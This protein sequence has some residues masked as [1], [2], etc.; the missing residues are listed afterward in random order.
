M[1]SAELSIGI[2]CASIS[3]YKP[4]FTR[5]F[6]STTVSDS[7]SENLT[8]LTPQQSEKF[9]GARGRYVTPH[10]GGNTDIDEHNWDLK[11]S[12]FVSSCSSPTSE[13]KFD[14]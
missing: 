4:L 6:Q 10:S 8:S 7:E 9:Q 12:G 1:S 14:L 2:A 3:T 5:H 11:D 13:R